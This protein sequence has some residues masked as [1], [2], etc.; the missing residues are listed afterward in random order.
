MP[1]RR[2]ELTGA[3][4]CRDIGGYRSAGGRRLRWGR[5]WRS[6]SLADL[7][8]DD[9]ALLGSLSLRTLVDLRHEDERVQQPNRLG[10]QAPP[11]TH[12]IGFYP[13]GSEA[14]MR[15]VRGRAVSKQEAHGLL[16]QMYRHLPLM[17]APHYARMLRVL[18]R[19]DAL[20]AL[21]HCTSGKDRTGFGMAVVMLALDIPRETILEDYAL[22]HLYRRNLSFLFGTDAD[23]EVV[24]AI[25]AADPMFLQASFDA[26]DRECGGTQAFLQ[27]RLG[28]TDPELARLQALLLE[29]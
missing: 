7:T 3:V 8:A 14:L 13:H 27:H 18:L 9:Q 2:L 10:V 17:H 6:D 26:I 4:N 22:T 1:A 29:D 11:Q 15:R 5:L 25:K 19:P 24:E 28:L 12:A 20:P 23:P 16:L 21:V